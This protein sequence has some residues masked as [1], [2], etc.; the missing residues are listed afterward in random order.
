MRPSL[1]V[2]S[3]SSGCQDL[4][5]LSDLDNIKEAIASDLWSLLNPWSGEG[6]GTEVM[7]AFGLSYAYCILSLSGANK[8]MVDNQNNHYQRHPSEGNL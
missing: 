2:L 7:E 8:A 3:T 4:S 6:G 1:S 5:D